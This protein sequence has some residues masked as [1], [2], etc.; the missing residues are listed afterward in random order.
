MNKDTDTTTIMLYSLKKETGQER[1]KD[2]STTK[3][4]QKTIR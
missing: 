2:K 1:P 4:N 3:Q